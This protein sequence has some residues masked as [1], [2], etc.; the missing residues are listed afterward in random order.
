MRSMPIPRRSHQTA[1]LLNRSCARSQTPCR[2]PP[3][4][5]RLAGE[6][7]TA[8]FRTPHEAFLAHLEL[9]RAVVWNEP[10]NSLALRVNAD[11][12]IIH[13]N[14]DV[15]AS[16]GALTADLEYEP[17]SKRYT[18]TANTNGLDLEKVDVLQHSM[19]AT[20][21]RLSADLSGSGTLDNP[22]LSA[23]LGIPDLHVRG[24]SFQ[25]VD[26]QLTAQNKHTEFRLRS[27]VEKTSIQAHGTVELTP[28]YPA[29]ITLDTGTIPISVLL[30]RFSPGTQQDASGQMEI[31]ATVQG[32]LQSPAQ[33]QAHAQI[34]TLQVQQKS[35]ALS[36]A[37]SIRLDYRAGVLQ[38]IGAEFKGQGTDLRLNSSVPIQVPGSMNVTAD[39]SVALSIL[40]PWTNGGHS[41][42]Q[43]TLQLHAQGQKTQPQIGGRVQIIN[44][45]YTSDALPVGIEALNG[46]VSIDGNHVNISNLSAKAG[47]GTVKVTGTAVYGQSSALALALRAKS[48]R[49]RQSGVRVVS[50]AD[51]A[52][53]GSLNAS[54]LSGR[55]TVDKLDFNEGSDLSEILG[56]F[57]SDTVS[58]PSTLASNIK[59]NVSVHSAEDLN[60]TSSQL[61]ISGSANLNAQGTL[62]QPI[63]LGR[64]SLTFPRQTF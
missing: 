31:H 26:A 42:G 15:R 36:N 32:P 56:Q 5:R 39:G 1:S 43:V 64:V 53:T 35:F 63:I 54:T 19:G 41:S 29:N 48:V 3:F 11:K 47:G 21:G 7:R 12:Q 16:A 2:D 9:T 45:L 49:I 30:T 34:L 51:P 37:G 17:S 13:L 46:D 55:V 14:R 22:Q 4:A 8:A 18:I 59:L 60:L 52:W 28:G 38:L 27:T 25:H 20:T 10:L 33:L 24:Q 62:A 50:D 57:S 44:A 61:S 58:A 40:Q 6:P 23:Q